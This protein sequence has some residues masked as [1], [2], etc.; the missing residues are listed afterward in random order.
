VI[1]IEPFDDGEESSQTIDEGRIVGPTPLVVAQM[2][3][4]LGEG[5]AFVAAA[6]PQF[7][8]TGW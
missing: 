1:V 5:H 7:V 8:H 6:D 2:V 3:R 4:D